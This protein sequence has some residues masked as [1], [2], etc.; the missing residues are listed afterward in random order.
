M[1]SPDLPLQHDAASRFVPY[2]I[3]V[4]V[5]LAAIALAGS[6]L[7]AAALGGWT[8]GLSGTLTVQVLP[9]PG[10]PAAT[11]KDIGAA[12]KILRATS[13][14]TAARAL[15]ERSSRALLKPWLGGGAMA[16]EIPVPRLIDV[17]VRPGAALDMARLT[18]RL[19]SAVPTA[20]I[21]DHRKWLS[22]L[23]GLANS[24]EAIALIVLMLTAAA[25]ACAVIFAA[26][27]GLSVHKRVIDILHLIGAPDQ[28]IARQFERRAFAQGLIGGIVGLG[29]AIATLL[30][31]GRLFSGVELFDLGAV[32]FGAL[33][34]IALAA[35][36][37]ATGLIALVTARMTVL[38]SLSRRL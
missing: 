34:W 19:R 35:L 14:I 22:R 29:A 21:D 37:P 9:N 4:M 13:G 33:H 7:V 2:V 11:A 16:P 3:A 12:L 17:S 30:V 6:M 36:A 28:Y 18:S 10:G 32:R 15:D 27:S 26:R 5:Y 31:M 8:R 25:A 1:E 23:F 38:R 24:L 20:E